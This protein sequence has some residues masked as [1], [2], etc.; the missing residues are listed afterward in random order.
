MV[1]ANEAGHHIPSNTMYQVWI[2]N[3]NRPIGSLIS[4]VVANSSLL[5]IP[6]VPPSTPSN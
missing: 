3:Y 5:G 4:F 2:L 1:S 6:I